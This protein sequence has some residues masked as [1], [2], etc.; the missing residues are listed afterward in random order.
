MKNVLLSRPLKAAWLSHPVTKVPFLG[1]RATVQRASDHSGGAAHMQEAHS[2][3]FLVITSDRIKSN[4]QLR[5]TQYQRFGA[6]PR[7]RM[8]H[9]ESPNHICLTGC[10]QTYRLVGF[11]VGH[12][13]VVKPIVESQVSRIWL[14]RQC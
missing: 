4:L 12:F 3:E 7:F 2:P 10:A 6:F 5:A 14:Q 9:L 13:Y 11:F 8:V 1:D